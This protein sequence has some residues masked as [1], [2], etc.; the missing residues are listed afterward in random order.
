MDNQAVWLT[1]AQVKK[2]VPHDSTPRA[3]RL[4]LRVRSLKPEE[5]DKTS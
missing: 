2:L 5:E 4:Y 1:K 3:G